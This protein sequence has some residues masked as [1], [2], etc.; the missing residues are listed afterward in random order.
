VASPAVH[1]TRQGNPSWMH[2]RLVG[3]IVEAVCLLVWLFGCLVVWLVVIV[4][5][6]VCLFSWLFVCLWTIIHA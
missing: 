2:L 1:C 5:I 4:V 6:V 3:L